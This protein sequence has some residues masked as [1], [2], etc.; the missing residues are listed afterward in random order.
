MND[1]PTNTHKGNAPKMQ[2]PKLSEGIN[3]VQFKV[4]QK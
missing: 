3:K 2:K 1:T 4:L